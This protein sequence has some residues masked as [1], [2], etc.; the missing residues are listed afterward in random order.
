M[1]LLEVQFAGTTVRS[2]L[3]GVAIALAVFLVLRLFKAVLVGRLAALV[4]RTR[5]EWDDILVAALRNTKTLFLVLV[6]LYTAGVLFVPSDRLREVLTAAVVLGV[7]VQGGIWA[8]AAIVFWLE[9]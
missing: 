4:K 7:I 3:L 9:S 1:E 5:T 8:N 6:A 2:W